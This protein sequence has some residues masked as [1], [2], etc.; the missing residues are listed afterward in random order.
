MKHVP[1]GILLLLTVLN[2]S[3]A[4][5]SLPALIPLPQQVVARPGT[6]T[7][8][9]GT[10]IRASAGAEATA[11]C[12]AEQLRRSTGFPLK[13]EL[14][15]DRN[16]PQGD[17]L[18]TTAQANASL[19]AEGYA[20]SV[21]ADAVVISAPQQAGGFYA[22]QTLFQLLPPE[23]FAESVVEN[24]AWQIPCVN[25]TDQPRFAWRGLMLDSGHDFQNKEFVECFINLM[26]RHKFNLFHWHLTDLGTW[27]IEIKGHPKLLDPATRARGVKPGHY[28][29]DEIREVVR[30][31]AA[32]HVTILP[33]IDIPGHSTPALLAYP[34]LDCPLPHDEKC[35]PYNVP[36]KGE[37]SPWELCVG[38]EKTYAFLEDV[39]GQIV[40]LFPGP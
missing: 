14:A 38:N 28:T 17:I 22:V 39:L 6:F 13:V 4:D 35:W 1:A 27:S 8:K 20:M 16:V 37:S 25:I 3:A 15:T 21:T 32:R 40:E 12:L 31:A 10:S 11:N 36:A 30:Y 2:A 29:Q 26:A 5:L 33:E 34:E 19:G 23:N 7:L 18:I 24:V 9:P